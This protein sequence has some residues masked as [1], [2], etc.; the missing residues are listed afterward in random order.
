MLELLDHE[1]L[2]ERVVRR[3]L[4]SA[5]EFV[6]L[7]TANLKDMHV[8]RGLSSKYHSF[9]AILNDLAGRGV[10]IRILHASEPSAS[11]QQSIQKYRHLQDNAIEL[12][13]CPRVHMKMVVVDGHA[14][15]AGSANITGAGLGEK[16]K[17]KRNFEVG[18][19][20]DETERIEKLMSLFDSVWMGSQ[21]QG[22][23]R[24]DVCI[25]PLDKA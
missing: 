16:S 13:M 4:P 14:A 23:R 7:A 9:L 5:R 18:Y 6:W 2:N 17:H 25:A 1:T 11:F 12:A 15:Y 3:L 22:C 21:C 10:N 20:T 19:I 8:R 24:R